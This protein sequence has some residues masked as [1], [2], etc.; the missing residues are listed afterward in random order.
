MRPRRNTKGFSIPR[1]CCVD[2]KTADRNFWH[3]H[4]VQ[5]GLMHQSFAWATFNISNNR[6]L[7]TS[8]NLNGNFSKLYPL[9]ARSWSRFSISRCD[10]LSSHI[11]RQS[12]G[13]RF[14]I[15]IVTRVP[16]NIRTK[17]V[18]TAHNNASQ[19]DGTR[20]CFLSIWLSAA[21]QK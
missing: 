11:S 13:L 21:M 18:Q 14:V 5:F 20:C 6:H 16:C 4:V 15:I 10:A 17:S 9:K 2:S 3:P 7:A 1:F 8:T 12:F 19:P